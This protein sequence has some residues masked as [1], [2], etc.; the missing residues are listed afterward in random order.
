[1]NPDRWQ[2]PNGAKIQVNFEP[3]TKLADGTAAKPLTR[4]CI[5]QGASGYIYDIPIAMYRVS[6]TLIAADGTSKPMRVGL[7]EYFSG[8]APTEKSEPTIEQFKPTGELYF[9]A[10]GTDSTPVLRG[11]GVYRTTL[12]VVE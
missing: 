11:T 2:W 7:P 6:A 9:P 8:R 5:A 10:N 3:I 12:Y 1:M 4:S